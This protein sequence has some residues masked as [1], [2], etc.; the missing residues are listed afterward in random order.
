[1]PSKD[2][3]SKSNTENITARSTQIKEKQIQERVQER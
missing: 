3:P 2:V 1:M